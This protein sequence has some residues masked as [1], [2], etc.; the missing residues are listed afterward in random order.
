MEY[1]P[2]YQIFGSQYYEKAKQRKQ[3]PKRQPPNHNIIRINKGPPTSM[4][5]HWS[6]TKVN[7]SETTLKY[8]DPLRTHRY[9]R[10]TYTPCQH[11]GL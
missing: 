5:P 6:T 10:R 3:L 2:N 1:P 8:F 7:Q 11:S 4:I 9:H